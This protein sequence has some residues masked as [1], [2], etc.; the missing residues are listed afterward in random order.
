MFGSFTAPFNC[1]LIV[2]QLSLMALALDNPEK[3]T[4]SE[5]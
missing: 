5:M 3:V 1:T 4:E 2:I